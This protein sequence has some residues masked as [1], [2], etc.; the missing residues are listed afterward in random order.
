[1]VLGYMGFQGDP[2]GLADAQKNLLNID[3]FNE[4]SSYAGRFSK[5]KLEN[6]ILNI[7]KTIA[8]LRGNM[9][10]KIALFNMAVE[11]KRG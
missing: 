4:I 7:M 10:P 2:A 6:D 11:L 8:Y 5:E 3:R 1:M 9:N